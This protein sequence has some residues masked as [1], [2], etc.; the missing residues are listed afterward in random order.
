MA[1]QSIS[2]HARTE[3]EKT[4]VRS[5]RNKSIVYGIGT[6]SIGLFAAYSIWQLLHGT[7]SGSGSTL[8]SNKAS[9]VPIVLCK[10]IA[11]PFG[12]FTFL[13]GTYKTC[14]HYDQMLSLLDPKR[15]PLLSFDSDGNPE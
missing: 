11:I 4:H 10:A 9:D 2:L 8:V 12:F 15:E 3:K 13:I 5:H 6:A 1:V 14:Y 7:D